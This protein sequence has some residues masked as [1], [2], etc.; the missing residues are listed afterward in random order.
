LKNDYG[1]ALDRNGYAPSVISTESRCFVC[2]RSGRKLD[3]HE[4]WHGPNRDKSKR[5]GCWVPLCGDCHDKLHHRGGGLDAELKKTAQP[6][7]TEHY[8][9]TDEEFRALFGKSYV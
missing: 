4:V 5:L 3:R 7:V 1:E 6:L 2:G 9:W 8:G